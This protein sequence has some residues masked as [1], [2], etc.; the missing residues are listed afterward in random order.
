M[1]LGRVLVLPVALAVGLAGGMVAGIVAQG[2]PLDGVPGAA[3]ASKPLPSV[4]PIAP[5]TLLA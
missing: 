5:A 1:R 3:P 4:N 2:Q